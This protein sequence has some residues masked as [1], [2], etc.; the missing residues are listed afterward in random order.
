MVATSLERPRW[1]SSSSSVGGRAA[2]DDDDEEEGEEEE[3]EGSVV[4]G[5]KLFVRAASLN[6]LLAMMEK[7]ISKRSSNTCHAKRTHRADV[8][9]L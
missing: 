1:S 4:G 2:D 6:F 5:A 7:Q 3:E 8:S 9:R